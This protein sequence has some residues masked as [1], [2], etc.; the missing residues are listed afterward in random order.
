M[1]Q[2]CISHSTLIYLHR[3]ARGIVYC[4]GS[5]IFELERRKASHILPSTPHPTTADALITR[6]S[7]VLQAHRE[8]EGHRYI[9]LGSNKTKD[10]I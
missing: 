4:I 3:H 7:K 10:T 8:S 1:M 6:T 2:V 9:Q 5:Y